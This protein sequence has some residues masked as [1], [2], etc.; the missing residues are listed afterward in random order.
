MKKSSRTIIYFILMIL[1]IS[2]AVVG[3][4]LDL[5]ISEK[6][7]A[8][9]VFPAKA[10]SFLTVLVFM[11]SCFFYLGVLCR[12]LWERYV[13][14]S[15]RLIVAAAFIYLFLSTAALGGAKILNDPLFDGR[16]TGLRGTLPGSLIT[17]SAAFMAF[18]I[19]GSVVNGKRCEPDKIKTLIKLITVFTFGFMMAHYLNCMMERASYSLLLSEGSAAG[20][21]RWYKIPKGTKLLMSLTDLITSHPGS[22]VSSHVLYAVLFIIIFPSFS[23]VIPSLKKYTKQMMIIAGIWS[24]TVISCR[25]ISGDNYLTDIAFAALYS[26]KFCATYEGSNIIRDQYKKLRG[27]SSLRT[28]PHSTP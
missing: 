3:T 26:L 21:T 25:L 11:A 2:G 20:F 13:K 15:Q 16:F 12:Q 22:F 8:G 6:L 1:C 5:P 27:R 23:L 19:A 17:G 7:Y 18:F 4:F 24:V 14:T 9:D 28:D 10:I